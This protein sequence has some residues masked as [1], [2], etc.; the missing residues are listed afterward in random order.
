[1]ECQK[2]AKDATV[3]VTDVV[4]GQSQVTHFCEDHA[5]EHLGHEE[6]FRPPPWPEDDVQTDLR[7]TKSQIERGDSVWVSFPNRL[8]LKIPLQP[9]MRDGECLQ[10]RPEGK[11]RLCVTLRV[12]PESEAKDT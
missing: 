3:H 12:V 1:M 11:R 7:V 8:K 5:V 10:L 2:C 9:W 4:E 6:R